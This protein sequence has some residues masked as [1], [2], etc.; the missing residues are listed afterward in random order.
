MIAIPPRK[1]TDQAKRARIRAR[2]RSI[3]KPNFSFRKMTEQARHA[4]TRW[5]C[6]LARGL[7]PPRDWFLPEIRARRLILP[8]RLKG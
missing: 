1:M 7:Y 2:D 8:R 5:G 3:D 4:R 6:F